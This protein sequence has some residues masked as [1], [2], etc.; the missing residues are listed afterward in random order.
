MNNVRSKSDIDRLVAGGN[1]WNSY[2]VICRE[3]QPIDAVSCLALYLG[4]MASS[5]SDLRK[6]EVYSTSPLA[7]QEGVAAVLAGEQRRRGWRIDEIG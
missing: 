5:G 4:A 7:D 2:P 1:H 6:W 3:L